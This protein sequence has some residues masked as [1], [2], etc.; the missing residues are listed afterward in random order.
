[1]AK[2]APKETA[3]DAGKWTTPLPALRALAPALSPPPSVGAGFTVKVLYESAHGDAVTGDFYDVFAVGEG[4]VALVLGAV[5]AGGLEAA[6]FASDV[7]SAV[8]TVL[9]DVLPEPTDPARALDVLNESVATAER[10]DGEHLGA[11]YVTLALALLDTRTG[12]VTC[13]TAGSEPPFVLRRADGKGG[14]VVPLAAGG[15]M[16]GALPPAA[17]DATSAAYESQSVV[18]ESGDILVLFSDG[19]TQARGVGGKVF[20]HAG[21]VE[22]MRRAAPVLPSLSALGESVMQ[23]AKTFAGRTQRDDACLLLARRL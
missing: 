17:H 1:L 8:R 10:L 5:T 3:S 16:L 15:P 21:L 22:A 13:S 2:G 9:C 14:E 18:M 11:T 19:V 7:R 6:A 23:R 4:R 20:G 12:E